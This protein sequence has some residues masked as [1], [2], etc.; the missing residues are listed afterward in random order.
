MGIMYGLKHFRGLK[1]NILIIETNTHYIFDKL[2][3]EYNLTTCPSPWSWLPSVVRKLLPRLRLVLL[4]CLPHCAPSGAAVKRSTALNTRCR[5]SFMLP[6]SH[7]Q[8]PCGV[9]HLDLPPYGLPW[10]YQGPGGDKEHGLVGHSSWSFLLLRDLL[11][12]AHVSRVSNSSLDVLP[13]CPT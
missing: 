13:P 6:P 8:E 1:I 11:P 3:H 4:W 9:C 5:V 12:P 7:H 10:K 2:K